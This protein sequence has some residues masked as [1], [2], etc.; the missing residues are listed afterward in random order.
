M[1]ISTF[2][3][4]AFWRTLF[5]INL[6]LIVLSLLQALVFVFFFFGFKI[7]LPAWAEK[8]IGEEIEKTG[9]AVDFSNATIDLFG[10]VS[11]ENVA[12]RFNGTPEN[13]F[14]AEKICCLFRYV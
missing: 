11:M 4:N 8:R 7:S 3:L 12:V 13:F 1:K 10:N 9:L 5:A 6:F 2:I 14:K